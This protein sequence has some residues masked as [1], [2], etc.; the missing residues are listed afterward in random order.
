[1]GQLPCGDLVFS[2]ELF[3]EVIAYDVEVLFLLA[4]QFLTFVEVVGAGIFFG[5]E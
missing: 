2:H 3:G 4:F 1:L 5:H